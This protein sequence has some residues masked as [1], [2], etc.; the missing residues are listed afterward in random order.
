[1]TRGG[2]FLSRHLLLPVT[3]EC[4]QAFTFV[5]QNPFHNTKF[6]QGSFLFCH[7]SIADALNGMNQD[8]SLRSFETRPPAQTH[9]GHTSLFTVADEQDFVSHN[10][11]YFP[12]GISVLCTFQVLLLKNT[13]LPEFCR[14]PSLISK[15][16]FSQSVPL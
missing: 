2:C 14:I 15:C 4:F 3:R 1:M 9:R 5:L 10:N 13:L 16:Q 12:P 11:R 7:K 8:S 6:A